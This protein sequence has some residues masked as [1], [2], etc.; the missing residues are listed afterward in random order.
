MYRHIITAAGTDRI[1]VIDSDGERYDVTEIDK[2]AIDSGDAPNRTLFIKI[3]NDSGS[4][5]K[6]DWFVKML[7]KLQS[8]I[9]Q[10]EF[11]RTVNDFDERPI[12]EEKPVFEE[13]CNNMTF[14]DY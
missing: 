2:S 14:S 11:E 13:I 6:I 8:G 7:Q 12:F 1:H 3:H 9:P 10:I 5:D 4:S